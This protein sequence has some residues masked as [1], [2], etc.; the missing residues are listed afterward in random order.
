MPALC[1]MVGGGSQVN[2][3][4]ASHVQNEVSITLKIH[5]RT[6]AHVEHTMRGCI[7]CSREV[8]G[9]A[10]GLL[11]IGQLGALQHKPQFGIGAKWHTATVLADQEAM[12]GDIRQRR[13]GFMSHLLWKQGRGKLSAGGLGEEIELQVKIKSGMKQA[14]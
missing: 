8:S 14:I 7:N 1:F 12:V 4:A 11:V 3:L 5:R 13:Y 6:L 10:L 2:S 9:V